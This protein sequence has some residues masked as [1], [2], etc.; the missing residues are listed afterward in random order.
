M[1]ASVLQ[2]TFVR[3][4]G[5]RDRVHVTRADATGVGWSFPTYG[6]RLPHDLCHLVVEDA[7]G[8]SDGFWGLVDDH[9]D[10]ALID[11]QATL[12]RHGRP[13]VDE[14]G[15]DFSG[16]RRAEEAV[17]LLAS[18]LLVVDHD[19]LLAVVRSE[20][21]SAGPKPTAPPSIDEISRHLGFDR[22]EAVTDAIV[23]AITDRLRELGRR[24]RALDDGEAI[25]LGFAV[26][27]P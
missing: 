14:P 15:F 26:P 5:G 6:D 23:A 1:M 27:D 18:P 11:N 17:A 25:T 9:V 4:H 12:V 7:L 24:W 10:V 2:A 13:L 21:P 19:G 8:L 3:T 22:P 16:L 20:P